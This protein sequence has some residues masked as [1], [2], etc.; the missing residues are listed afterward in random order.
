MDY[1]PIFMKIEQQHCLI[2]GGGAVAARKA[3]LFIKSG[4]IVT[5]VAPKLGNEMSFH[6]LHNPI[7]ILNPLASPGALNPG[8]YCPLSSRRR[9]IGPFPSFKKRISSGDSATWME[10]GSPARL[11]QLLIAWIRTGDT[12]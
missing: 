2:V 1:L 3:D 11:V 10:K 12:V 7:Q 8:G 5:V 9:R 4:A 6:F